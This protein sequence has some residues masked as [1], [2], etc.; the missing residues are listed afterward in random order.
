MKK[1]EVI[2]SIAVGFIVGFLLV[3][4]SGSILIPQLEQAK[5]VQEP[6]PNVLSY[7][8]P[9]LVRA[10]QAQ[11]SQPTVLSYLG[12]SLVRAEQAQTSQPETLSTLETLAPKD[13]PA[14]DADG[15]LKL[16]AES[17]KYWNSLHLVYQADYRAPGSEA[18]D[19]TYTHEFWLKADGSTKLL[20]Y[21]AEKQPE[22]LWIN[23]TQSLW[24]QS[25][26]SATYTRQDVPSGADLP[27]EVNQSTGEN[28]TEDTVAPLFSAL[29]IPSAMNDYIFP[30]GLAQAMSRTE[31]RDGIVQIV[32]V[33]GKEIVAG[34][35]TFILERRIGPQSDLEHPGKLHQYWVD[36]QTGVILQA[37]ILDP[38]TGAWTQKYTAQVCD[39]DPIFPEG[40]FT[41][42]P[43]PG[44][45]LKDIEP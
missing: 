30:R 43:E 4:L 2:S 29:L 26:N 27:S 28:S 25:Y 11:E 14:D 19:Q 24:S 3:A 21:D 20:I 33:V 36:V 8:G 6:Q 22:L 44:S 13:K 1:H 15:L 37:E 35:E 40:E 23:D 7:L 39:V 38:E 5:Q 9:S 10:E 34:R 17:P 16:M 41:F 18:I 42:T 12:P 31:L 45:I 32:E